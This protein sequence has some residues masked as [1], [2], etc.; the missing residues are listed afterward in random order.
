MIN[1][2]TQQLMAALEERFNLQQ[3]PRIT[4]MLEI[5]A[6]SRAPELA[7]MQKLALPLFIP[8]ISNYPWSSER[9]PWLETL[10]RGYETILAELDALIASGHQ[11]GAYGPAYDR[12]DETIP[13]QDD[14]TVTGW[15]AFYFYRT[16]R[17]QDHACRLCPQTAE[18]LEQ[19]PIGQEAL[20]S[21]LEPGAVIP[22]HTDGL[23]FFITCHLGLRVPPGCS[24]RVGD[25]TRTWAPGKTILFNTSFLHAAEN[26]S[27]ER[28][29]VLLVDVWH[30]ELNQAEIEAITF[31]RPL[32]EREFGLKPDTVEQ[33]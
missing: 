15:R 29:I 11:F 28:R 6:G 8:G 30:P 27:S 24:I 22:E 9:Y 31:L 16:G 14:M 23:N 12:T 20:F 19:V 3:I 17:R 25:E 32:L 7:P 4:G 18:L 33:A 13:A 2:P 5:L 21:V 26:P 10:E 1:L